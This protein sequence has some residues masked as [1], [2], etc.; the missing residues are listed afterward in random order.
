MY[1]PGTVLRFE[2]GETATVLTNGNVLAQKD[3]W[4]QIMSMEDWKC[5]GTPLPP[6]V[7]AHVDSPVWAAHPQCVHDMMAEVK[8]MMGGAPAPEP[9]PAPV[10]TPGTSLR[11]ALDADTYRIAIV[12]SNGIL[13]VKSV[14]ETKPEYV[15]DSWRFPLAKKRF[16]TEDEWRASLPEGGTITIKTPEERQASKAFKV[17]GNDVEKIQQLAKRYK[18]ITQIG[19]K[20]P[21]QPHLAH[22][23]RN[24]EKYT[25]QIAEAK[26]VIREIKA[27]EQDEPTR[28]DL[29]RAINEWR[30]ACHD[31]R[32]TM[33]QMRKVTLAGD[34]SR[35]WQTH[36]PQTLYVVLAQ[37]IHV[38]ITPASRV[39]WNSPRVMTG[40]YCGEM[41]YNSL[42][43]MNVAKDDKGKPKIYA[44]YRQAII[45]LGHHF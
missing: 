19:E 2:N 10:R 4:R 26:K 14:T 7:P 18:V 11:W 45:P 3:N 24:L 32:R 25:T 12:I 41:V 42:E 6:V 29:Y 44:F 13:Q 36:S 39:K 16:A 33:S 9:E 37:G 31:R 5:L 21:A 23:Q 15:D 1:T 40:I 20:T 8:Q 30:S 28:N 27:R 34:T 17:S 22:L 38:A 43:E 35:F